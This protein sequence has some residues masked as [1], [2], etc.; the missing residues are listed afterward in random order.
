MF[1]VQYYSITNFQ[2]DYNSTVI[3]KPELTVYSTNTKV[4][5]LSTHSKLNIDILNLTS[6]SLFT[7]N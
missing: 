6:T 3:N 4:D 7:K 1:Q 2:S 5:A